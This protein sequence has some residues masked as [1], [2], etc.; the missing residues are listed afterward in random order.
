M[1][2]LFAIVIVALVALV[3]TLPLR[4]GSAEP[5]GLEDPAEA[6]LADLEARKESKYREIRDAENDRAAGKLSDQAFGRL[7]AELRADAI[8]ILKRIDRL[9]GGRPD[10][11]L[12]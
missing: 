11:P 7:D 1:E 2:L 10:G 5:G 12:D 3:V 8:E 4:R 6:E 9:R